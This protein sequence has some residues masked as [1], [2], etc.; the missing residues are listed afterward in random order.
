MSRFVY[1]ENNKDSHFQSDFNSAHVAKNK[2]NKHS[3]FFERGWGCCFTTLDSISGYVFYPFVFFIVPEDPGYFADF[4]EA[5]AAE[6]EQD[7][8]MEIECSEKCARQGDSPHAD[9]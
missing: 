3:A 9:Y 6:D 1:V 2:V 4:V 7:G 5:G 8:P